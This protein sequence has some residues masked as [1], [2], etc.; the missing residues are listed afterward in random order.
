RN[1]VFDVFTAKTGTL[2]PYNLSIETR[3]ILEFNTAGIDLAASPA[4]T[5][6]LYTEFP[7]YQSANLR[8][9]GYAGDGTAA[10]ADATQTGTLLGQFSVLTGT[11]WRR[12][13]LNRTALQGLMSQS[14][15]VGLVLVADANTSLDVHGTG[16]AEAPRLQFWSADPPIVPTL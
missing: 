7:W 9:Y 2:G 5:L 1:G 3:S 14:S 6:D 15:Y 10:L 12:V 4:V 16:S 8:V 13:A 11:A